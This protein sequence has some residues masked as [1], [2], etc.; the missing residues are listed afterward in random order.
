ML[1]RA[2]TEEDR[3]QE[4]GRQDVPGSSPSQ[5]PPG[6]R[7]VLTRLPRHRT[8]IR[9]LFASDGEFRALCDEYEAC[10]TAQQRLAGGTPAQRELV[11]EYRRLALGLE[12]ELLDRIREASGG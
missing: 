9:E 5:D 2:S 10:R 11:G 3:A 7:S 8:V 12:R 4:A 1:D 6:L